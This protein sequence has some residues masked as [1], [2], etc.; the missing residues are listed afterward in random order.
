MNNYIKIIFVAVLFVTAISCSNRDEVFEREQ[1]KNVFAIVSGDNNVYAMQ[2]DYR[3][4]VSAG[5]ISASLGGTNFCDKDIVITMVEDDAV[6][7][8]YNIGLYQEDRDRYVKALSKDKYYFEGYTMTIKAGTTTASLP[9]YVKPEGLSPDS[10]FYIPLRVDTYN[11]G[12]LNMDKGYILY[13]VHTKNWWCTYNGTQYVSRGVSYE[14][15]MV[16]VN[17]Y[18]NK[19]LYPFGPATIR[20]MPGTER[21]KD[22]NEQYN[23]NAMAMMLEISDNTT[24][25]IIDDMVKNGSPVNILPYGKLDIGMVSKD[26]PDYDPNYPNIAIACDDEGYHRTYKTL[27][28]QYRFVDSRGRNLRITEEVRL[29]YIENPKDPRFFDNK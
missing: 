8:A 22:A 27:L 21:E 15:G 23:Y 11:A 26:D 25:Y 18:V 6:L 3:L 12:E 4:P 20:M 2:H 10:V 1:Y 28:L 7:E 16:P 14:E 9:V 13:E 17:L 19:N 29:G 5:Y 24:E